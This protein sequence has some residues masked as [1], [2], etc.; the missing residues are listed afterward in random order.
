MKLSRRSRL[1]AAFVTLCCL[2]FTQ[3]AVAAYACPALDKLP[4]TAIAKPCPNMDMQQP[5]LCKAHCEAGQQTVDANV[6]LHITPFVAAVLAVVVLEQPEA[7]PGF[8]GHDSSCLS[9][10]TAPPLSIRNCCFRL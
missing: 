8:V 6:P 2:L 10:S 5:G 9:H 3:L 7:I 1:V 4:A